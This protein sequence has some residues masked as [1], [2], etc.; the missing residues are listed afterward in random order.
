M[1]TPLFAFHKW[2]NMVVVS[3]M[4]LRV[5]RVRVKSGVALCW[6]RND[7]VLLSLRPRPAPV[8]AS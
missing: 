2:K 5:A 8:A 3:L 7:Q 6:R 1:K 4:V